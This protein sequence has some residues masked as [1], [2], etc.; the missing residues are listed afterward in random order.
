[1]DQKN[2]GWKN[3][4]CPKSGPTRNNTRINGFDPVRRYTE[5]SGLALSP[6]QIAPSSG[7]PIMYVINDGSDEDEGRIGVYDSGSG[8]RL[9]TLTISNQTVPSSYDWESLTVGS[10]GIT[11]QEDTRGTSLGS[12]CLYIA[13]VG[14][15]VARDTKGRR[16]DRTENDPYRIIKIREPIIEILPVAIEEANS[17]WAIPDADVSMLAF[18]YNHSS[19]PTDYADCEAVF[20]DPT[21][22]GFGGSPGDLYLITKWNPTNVSLTRLF[23]IPTNAWSIPAQGQASVGNITSQRPLVYSPLAVGSYSPDDELLNATWTGAEL[24]HDG[25][26]IA[27]SS[28]D[29]TSIFLRCPG[30]T[31]AEAL[32]GNSQSCHS[33]SHPSRGQVET[34][35]WTADGTQHLEIPEGPRPRMG[36]TTMIYDD[37]DD[38]RNLVGKSSVCPLMEWF[39]AS[40]RRTYCRSMHDASPKPDDWCIHSTNLV[41]VTYPDDF[42]MSGNQK[43]SNNPTGK[44]GSMSAAWQ[45]AFSLVWTLL[46]GAIVSMATVNINY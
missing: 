10:C 4:V 30:S 33:F 31:V 8:Q 32:T 9:L 42:S 46:V 11:D 12:S 41:P 15:N 23:K 27:L 37:S 28:N 21:G 39:V 25:T 6:T 16:S 3:V 34:S 43:N 35:A 22:W 13:D 5:I 36:W 38:N 40:G 24:T 45:P 17:T 26:V 2:T 1:M 20:L 7:F 18:D 14:D 29:G 19:S 44:S